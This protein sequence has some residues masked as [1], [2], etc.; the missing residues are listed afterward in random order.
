MKRHRKMSIIGFVLFCMV[1]AGW[2]S[3]FCQQSEIK[4]P[5]YY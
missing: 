2:N 5:L 3:G 1:F 4:A